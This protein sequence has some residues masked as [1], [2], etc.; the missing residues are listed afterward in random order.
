MRAEGHINSA[1]NVRKPFRT[2]D[3]TIPCKTPAQPR[4]PRM[5]RDKTPEARRDEHGLQH[6]SA[7][8]GSQRLIVKSEDGY[9]CVRAAEVAQVVHAEE[10]GDGVEP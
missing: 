1:I 9:Q 8:L 7:S 6:D 2:R 10:E 4:L 5:R 3:T